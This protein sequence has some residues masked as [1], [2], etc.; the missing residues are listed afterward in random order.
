M[1]LSLCPR[2]RSDIVLSV[3]SNIARL[4]VYKVNT[5]KKIIFILFISQIHTEINLQR[6]AHTTFSTFNRFQYS[7]VQVVVV[8]PTNIFCDLFQISTVSRVLTR[9]LNVATHTRR[10]SQRTSCYL[11]LHR[12]VIILL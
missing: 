9:K 7:R 2:H 11:L 5:F 3:C 6:V 8:V 1:I 4:V 10:I 12:V